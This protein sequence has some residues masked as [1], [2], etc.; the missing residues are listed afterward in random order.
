MAIVRMYLR[1]KEI[2]PTNRRM[3]FTHKTHTDTHTRIRTHNRRDTE[4][5]M[6]MNTLAYGITNCYCSIYLLTSKDLKSGSQREI[7][8]PVNSFP[9]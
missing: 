2:N 9:I 6:R 3:I 7:L 8:L 4:G 1:I 5:F